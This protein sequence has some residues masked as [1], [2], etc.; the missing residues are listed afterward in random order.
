MPDVNKK[1]QNHDHPGRIPSDGILYII[2]LK[3]S[4]DS[5]LLLTSNPFR[6]VDKHLEY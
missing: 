1:Q 5:I 4:K 2:K 3:K 6:H